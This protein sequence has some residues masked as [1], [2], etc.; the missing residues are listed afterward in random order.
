MAVKGIDFLLYVNTGTGE[1][2]TWTVVGGQRGASLSRSAD[3]VDVTNKESNEWTESLPGL[4][5]WSIDF[6]GLL[7]VDDTAY[8]ALKT[9]WKS[10]Q[11]V[12][13]KI[14]QDGGTAEGGYGIITDLSEDY[15]YDAEAT[16]SGSIEGTGELKTI[17]V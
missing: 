11:T 8:E 9:A 10:G 2:E 6:D 4:K 12:Y 13:V 16:V 14:E 3:T 5:S 7:V 17:T 15:P 1:T